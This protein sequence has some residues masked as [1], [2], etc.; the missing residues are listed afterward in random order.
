MRRPGY[1]ALEMA[2]QSSSG[3]TLDTD[4][5]GI[6]VPN[7]QVTQAHLRDAA[8]AAD[9]DGAR[10]RRDEPEGRCGARR[11]AHLQ[12][13]RAAA[14]YECPVTGPATAHPSSPRGCST[15]GAS[16]CAQL[17]VVDAP[18]PPGIVQFDLP[19]ASLAPDEYRVELAAANATGPRDEAKEMIPSFTRH[20]ELSRVILLLR[21]P[22]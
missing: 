13:H 7:L 17:Q 6:S 12:P 2:I 18:L 19:L 10:L 5:R 1:V 15:G 16:R 21:I 14:R 4:Y 11:V 3:A 8:G 9:A 22:Y 20:V